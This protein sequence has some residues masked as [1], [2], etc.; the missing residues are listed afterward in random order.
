MSPDDRD[1]G[2]FWTFSFL[3]IALGVTMMLAPN[4]WYGPSWH[5]FPQFPHDGFW[6]GLCCATIGSW[7][8]LTLWR[9]RLRGVLAQ[10]LLSLLFF[11]GGFVIWTSGITLAA[12][13]LYGHQGLMEAPFM[14]IVGGHKVI[15]STQLANRVKERK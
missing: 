3:M 10:R 12:A 8:L 1:L 14:M 6:M 9:Y 13:G 2:L 5:Y 11:L 4:N 7:Q 15:L